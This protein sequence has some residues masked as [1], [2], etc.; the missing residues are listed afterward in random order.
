M[1]R[2]LRIE[3]AEALYHITSRGDGREAI[4]LDDGDRELFSS[5]FADVCERFNWSCHVY[6]LMGNHYHL[7]IETHEDNLSQGMRQINGVYTQ[8]F[9]IR[10]RRVGACFQ[11]RY[12]AILVDKDA[13]LLELARYVVLNPVRAE[14]VRS[15]GDWPLSNYRSTTGVMDAPGWLDVNWTL[16]M[17]AAR[18]AASIRRY[19]EFVAGGKGLPSPWQQLRNQVYLGGDEFIEQMH[20]KIEDI[21]LDDVPKLQKRKLAKPLDHYEKMAASRDEAIAAVYRSGGYSQKAIAVFLVC[22]IRR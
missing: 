22:T 6:C 8:R 2:P 18:K 4:Y 14:M 5:V 9:N 17:F 15:A 11:G 3:F 1:A 7:L 20:K 10:H 13:Y 19:Q 21:S 12:K 16:S